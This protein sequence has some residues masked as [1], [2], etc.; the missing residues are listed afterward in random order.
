MT[1]LIASTVN[2]RTAKSALLRRTGLCH[3]PRS[4]W[5]Q[6]GRLDA[7]LSSDGDDAAIAAA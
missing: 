4:T 1:M 7:R 3:D 2:R 6:R 5:F